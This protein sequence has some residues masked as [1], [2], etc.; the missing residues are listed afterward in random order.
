MLITIGTLFAMDHFG[1]YGIS[2]TWPII[3]IVLGLLKLLERA[4]ARPAV[5]PAPTQG[6]PLP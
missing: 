2:R 5:S 4:A 1:P 6:G 3:L